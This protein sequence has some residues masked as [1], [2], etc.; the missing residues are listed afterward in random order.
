MCL[1]VPHGMFDA[2]GLCMERSV[3]VWNQYSFFSVRIPDFFL[4]WLVLGPEPFLYILFRT[5]KL[6]WRGRKSLNS[7]VLDPGLNPDST[8]C[9]LCKCEPVT[10]LPFAEHHL[11][12]WLQAP[13]TSG[14]QHNHPVSDGQT[15]STHTHLVLMALGWWNWLWIQGFPMVFFMERVSAGFL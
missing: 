13:R 1:P 10:W 11:C 4:H 14:S 8:T 3:Y 2:G 15:E 5:L 6:L 9:S 12:A 7:D